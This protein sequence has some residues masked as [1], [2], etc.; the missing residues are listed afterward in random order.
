MVTAVVNGFKPIVCVLGFEYVIWMMIEN[1]ESTI[2][3]YAVPTAPTAAVSGAPVFTTV[4][5]VAVSAVIASVVTLFAG[6][7][8][9]VHE[10][11]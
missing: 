4:I 9:P 3:M 8:K 11:R 5:T 6:V 1:V 7:A 2:G 10:T